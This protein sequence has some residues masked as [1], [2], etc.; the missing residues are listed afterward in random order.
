[1]S[2]ETT[3]REH[4]HFQGNPYRFQSTVWAPEKNG[5]GKVRFAVESMIYVSGAGMDSVNPHTQSND[6]MIAMRDYILVKEMLGYE[7]VGLSSSEFTELMKNL[8]G[9][10]K[11]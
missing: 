2:N 3:H 4:T 11:V 8:W 10:D 6:F 7:H 1:M 9:K 5:N